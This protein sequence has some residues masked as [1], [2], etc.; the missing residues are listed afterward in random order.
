[1]V[2]PCQSPQPPNDVAGGC[3]FPCPLKMDFQ[4]VTR[5]IRSSNMQLNTGL[6]PTQIP[7]YQY[8]RLQ[9][10]YLEKRRAWMSPD[11]RTLST[12]DPPFIISGWEKNVRSTASYDLETT[13]I[14][15]RSSVQFSIHIII[16]RF[17]LYAESSHVTLAPMYV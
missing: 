7:S 15:Q 3:R 10:V 6:S 12:T 2:D 11:D 16:I 8:I 17:P 1:M 13:L 9:M 4:L 5:D 14:S